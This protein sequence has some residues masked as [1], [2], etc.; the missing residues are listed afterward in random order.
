[1]MKGTTYRMVL[2]YSV[3]LIQNNELIWKKYI[4]FDESGFEHSAHHL[5]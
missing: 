4:Q 3:E 5:E 2:I 1:M